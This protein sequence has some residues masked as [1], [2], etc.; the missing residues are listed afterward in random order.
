MD[1]DYISRKL[2]QLSKYYKSKRDRHRA[3]TFE[4]AAAVVDQIEEPIT[5]PSVQ[6]KGIAKIGPGTIR[7]IKEI[8]ETGTLEEIQEIP[9]DPT[10]EL[11]T[12]YGIGPST[13]QELINQGVTGINDLIEKY[14]RGEIVL[15]ENQVHGLTYYQ[16][17]QERIPR[18]EVQVVGEY[19]ISALKEMNP[20]NIAEIVGSY[21]R[22][23]ESSGDID[24]LITHP[25]NYN[26]LQHIVDYL[27]EI[28]LI[29][30]VLS[31]G[32]LKFQGTYYSTYPETEGGFMRK[33][34]I[35]FV[36]FKSW[37][38]ATL[39]STGSQKL[40]VLMRQRALSRGMSLSEH[41]LFRLDPRNRNKIEEV[42][43]RSEEEIF[44]LV[45]LEYL[46]PENR[47]L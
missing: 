6:L 41:G 19:I 37:P 32:E 42:P 5:N 47:D 39:H 46:P 30:H 27:I 11:I 20:D 26:Y 18:E 44:D 4:Y 1:N 7:R 10:E 35:R 3:N 2:R 17:F 25:E 33:I 12:V 38:T 31:L 14:N 13:A 9:E 8:L 28:G 23:K 22:G 40:N 34:D 24:I 15:T 36:P 21:R 16:D 29:I 45:G 43:V